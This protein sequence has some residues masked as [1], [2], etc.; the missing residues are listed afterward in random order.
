MRGN[1]SFTRFGWCARGDGGR[2]AYIPAEPWR[3]CAQRTRDATASRARGAARPRRRGSRTRVGA[4]PAC[5]HAGRIGG[6][7]LMMAFTTPALPYPATALPL[8][9][10]AV[11][12]GG[13][14]LRPG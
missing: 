2:S 13:T 7:A 11:P 12:D 3:Q 6:D 8:T 1:I 14:E 10:T 9:R 5:R 4:Q